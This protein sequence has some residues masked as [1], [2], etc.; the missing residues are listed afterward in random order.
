MTAKAQELALDVDFETAR[1]IHRIVRAMHDG[2]CP[3]C[4]RL[5]DSPAMRVS[6]NP[7]RDLICP[8][9]AFRI[10]AE[11]QLEAMNTFAPVMERNL[12][13][14]EEWRKQRP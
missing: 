8:L 12:T 4:H 7:T 2:E 3:N 9:C 11:E 13:V 14:F 5:F 10:T 6:V 1:A